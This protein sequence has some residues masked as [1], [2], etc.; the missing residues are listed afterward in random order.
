MDVWPDA[1]AVTV[2]KRVRDMPTHS[3]LV[4]HRCICM[5]GRESHTHTSPERVALT[6]W[7]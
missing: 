7:L 5:S 3:R 2:R 4:I 6:L 1:Q